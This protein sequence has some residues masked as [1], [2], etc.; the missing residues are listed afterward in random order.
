M[1]SGKNRVHKTKEQCPLIIN[2]VTVNPG[3]IIVGDDN[4]VL[5]IPK[6]LLSYLLIKINNIRSTEHKIKAAVKA[7]GTLKQAR[8]DF[9]YDKPWIDPKDD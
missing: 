3:D 2:N 6:D 4:G 5:V 7:G 8:A 1:R 9:H